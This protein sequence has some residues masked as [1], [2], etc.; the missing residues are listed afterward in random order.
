MEEDHSR[1]V[2]G[3]QPEPISEHSHF[4]PK[5]AMP[6]LLS[7]K[8]PRF[9]LTSNYHDLIVGDVLKSRS[10]PTFITFTT[11]LGM[12]CLK[13]KQFFSTAVGVRGRDAHYWCAL[14]SLCSIS[15][16]LLLFRTLHS[17]WIIDNWRIISPSLLGKT[18]R[19]SI[20]LSDHSSWHTAVP[21][22]T[23]LHFSLIKVFHLLFLNI[24]IW[25]NSLASC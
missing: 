19:F 4:S 10:Y 12:Q 7:S 14:L 5:A 3:L 25:S 15:N 1:G 18:R 22:T 2:P 9:I 8:H 6:E 13:L 11:V 24:K 17:A 16:F 23:V 21:Y 20:F